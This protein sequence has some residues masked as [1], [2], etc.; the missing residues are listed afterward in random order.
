M[1]DNKT[2]A[3]NAALMQIEK[4]FGRGSVMCLGDNPAEHDISVVSTG[5][6]GLDAALGIG[7][8]PRGRI[9][10]IYGPE[11]SGK[12]T[13][14]L[15][16]IAACQRAGG[17]AAFVDAEHALDPVYAEKVGVD[18]KK[19][20]VSQP[21]TG[22]QGLEITDMLVRSGAVDMVVIDSVA[23][24]TPR[25]EIEGDMGD[26][27]MGLQARLM[28]Q[29][30]R[31]LTSSI[32]KSNTLVIFI[33]QIRMKI[34]VMFGNPETTTGGNALKFYASVRLDIR[35]T[36]AIKKGEE[37][38]GNET[39]VKVVKNKIAPPFRQVDFEIIYGE[40]I[41]LISELIELGVA[42]NLVDKSGAWYSYQGTRIGQGKDNVREYLKE[43]KAVAN[44]IEAKLRQILLSGN[45]TAP[46]AAKKS[47]SKME[48][49][50]VEA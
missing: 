10:E 23:A 37:I 19:L 38:I 39:R 45:A 30:L 17:T 33:N 40:G 25:A 6:L 36:G 26:S 14:T 20:L 46:D 47:K 2:K 28:S 13:L 31:K 43:N 34:G 32:K 44:E 35:R 4:Q 3:L 42:H 11:S 21:D 9:V 7:G 48:E 50:L 12:T 22:E 27:H 29:A 5:S 8:L 49:D 1:E 16:T 18:V 24:L 15:Q 41:S